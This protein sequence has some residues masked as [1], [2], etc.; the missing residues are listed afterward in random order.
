MISPQ[1]SLYSPIFEYNVVF[2]WWISS[3]YSLY[4]LCT[5]TWQCNYEVTLARPYAMETIMCYISANL[6]YNSLQGT[7]YQGALN[8]ATLATKAM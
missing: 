7:M 6:C 8:G 5:A 2:V 4:S 3:Q 1:C